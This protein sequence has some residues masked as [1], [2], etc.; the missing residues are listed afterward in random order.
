MP[1]PISPALGLIR[2]L[3]AAGH[4]DLAARSLTLPPLPAAPPAPGTQAAKSPRLRRPAHT[5]SAIHPAP[6]VP[7]WPKPGI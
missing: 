5:S 4:H 6:P 2:A 7:T 1:R 3:V